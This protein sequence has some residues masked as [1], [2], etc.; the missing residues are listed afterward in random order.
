MTYG[1]RLSEAIDLAKES[2]ES[3]AEA[4]D[5]SVQAVGAVIRGDTRAMTAENN[6]KAAR[7]LAVNPFWLA[8]GLETARD[9]AGL[10]ESLSEEAILQ[11]ANYEKMNPV[12][13]Q[14]LRLLMMAA[15]DGVDPTQIENAP[16]RPSGRGS[17]NLGGM[18]HWGALDEIPDT[19]SKRKP[20]K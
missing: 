4:L 13:R 17:Q 18:S 5:I 11:A 15:R 14:R 6:A 10:R 8:T 3:L 20:E 12:E 1:E 16:G 9:A 19:S 7:F 2:R